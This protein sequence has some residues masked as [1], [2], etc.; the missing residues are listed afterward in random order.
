MIR[1]CYCTH[2]DALTCSSTAH[3]TSRFNA[4]IEYG[5]CTC[6]CHVSQH[7]PISEQQWKR[8][9]LAATDRRRKQTGKILAN[10]RATKKQ[11]SEAK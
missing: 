2:F 5:A 9:R 11:E 8:G 6:K 10:A 4:L 3:S 7:Q 1:D